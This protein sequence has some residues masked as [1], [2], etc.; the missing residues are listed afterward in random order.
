MR[1]ALFVAASVALV[2]MPAVAQT[3]RA[4]SCEVAN[5]YELSDGGALQ[6]QSGGG[7]AGKKGDRF[8]IDIKTGEMTGTVPFISRF[9]TRISV[10]DSGTSPSGS[11]LK[12]M[13]SSPPD[14]EFVNVAFLQIQGTVQN[15][16]RPF[17]CEDSAWLYSGVCRVAF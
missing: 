7:L 4:Y 3:P 14:G 15:P 8:R 12:V 1:E 16:S 11:F 13:Y 17:V 6:S 5:V 10:L 2:S 9:W